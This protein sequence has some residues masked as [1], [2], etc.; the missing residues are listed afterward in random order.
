MYIETV[1]NRNSSPTILLREGWREGKKVRKRTLAN[2]T[3][4]PSQK[5]EALRKLLKGESLFSLQETFSIERSLPHGHVAAIL[6][7]IRKMGIESILAS[8]P[9]K[10]RSLVL[11]MLTELLLH[12]TSKLGTTRLWHT[13]T[14]AETLDVQDADEDDL[15]AALDWLYKRQGRIENKLAKKHLSADALVLYDTSNSYY[16][17]RCCPL[18]FFGHGKDK[19]GKRLIAYGVMADSL[20]RP[21]SIQVYPGNTGD[22]T[23]VASQVTKL[24]KKF[25]VK[26]V[27]LAGDRGM[28]TQTQIDHLSQYPGVGWLSA[29]RFEKIRALAEEGKL[30]FSTFETENL[31]EITSESFPGERLIVCYNSLLAQDRRRTRQELLAATEELLHKIVQEVSR[32][33]KKPLTAAE[34]GE[35]VGRK[36]NKYKVGKHFI[37]RIE[38]GKF[39]FERNEESLQQES[40]LDGIYVIRTSEEATRLSKEE[41]VRSYKSLSLVENLFRTIKGLGIRLRPIYLRDEK[42]VRAHIFLCMLAYYVE[43]EMRNALK[44]LLF[45]DEELDESR[46]SRDPVA[47]A[48]PSEAAKK[49]RSRRTTRDGLPVHSWDTLLAELGTLCKNRMRPKS[50]PNL[51]PIEQLT[52]PTPLQKRAFELL[53]LFPVN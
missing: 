45:D 12:P 6:G 11:A 40:Q 30:P 20:G 53:G 23:T 42:R 43:W 25:G 50:E 28:L 2:I 14:L 49:K 4:W 1:P 32:R 29:L 7:T 35:K 5:I 21:V 51:L 17:G 22:P 24:R 31:A 3:H 48:T 44:E 41:A 18:A 8:R 27:V 34:I 39:S 10:E 33:T 13:T 15:Y 9:C 46:C 38:D 16:E 26:R 19:K 52:E 47:A 36:G 37:T